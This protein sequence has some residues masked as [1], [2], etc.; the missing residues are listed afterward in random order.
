MDDVHQAPITY[1]IGG[2]GMPFGEDKRTYEWD[3]MKNVDL[4]GDEIMVLTA[5]RTSVTEIGLS[6]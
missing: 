1:D 4:T 2:W 6:L 3:R 5:D